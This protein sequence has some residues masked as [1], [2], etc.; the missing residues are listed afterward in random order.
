MLRAAA[1]VV[2]HPDTRAELLEVYALGFEGHFDDA[3]SSYADHPA[4]GIRLREGAGTC[5]A[6]VDGGD[7]QQATP[8]VGQL[9]CHCAT[10]AVDHRA[11]VQTGWL[12]RD[13]RGLWTY[14]VLGSGLPGRCFAGDPSL[15]KCA[16]ENAISKGKPR[17]GQLEWLAGRP[18]RRAGRCGSLRQRG[19]VYPAVV[20]ALDATMILIA[21]DQ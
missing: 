19:C 10:L 8:H 17:S 6:D 13:D 1:R 12:K 21:G 9:S 7:S 11:E 5:A 18:A 15:R 16:T 14:G 3:G 2:Y 20:A 4:A